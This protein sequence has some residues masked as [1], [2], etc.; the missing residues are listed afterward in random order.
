M[1]ARNI[2]PGFF[3]NED[4]VEI[5][6]GGRLLF[7]GLWCMADRKGLLED[8]PKKIKLELMPYDDINCDKLLQELHDHSL[9][10][11]YNVNGNRYISVP[12]FSKHQKPHPNEKLSEI[13]PPSKSNNTEET[14]YQ[15]DKS[16]EPRNA[17][18]GSDILNPDILNKEY[19]GV[20]PLKDVK[21][22]SLPKVGA[23]IQD[24]ADKLYEEKKFA[25]V[26]A[27]VNSMIKKKV[28]TRAILHALTRVY[29]KPPDNKDFNP[30]AYALQIIKVENGNY[31]EQLF[32]KITPKDS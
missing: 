19:A 1:R 9:I 29:L 20:P 32:R 16:V 4:L 27:F 21:E 23:D 5:S 11:R 17:P 15:G 30:W 3:R 24:L 25:K 22:F 18:L 10:L 31:N 7:I 13:P 26:H 6:P 12:N 28:N 2:K 14:S 8:R